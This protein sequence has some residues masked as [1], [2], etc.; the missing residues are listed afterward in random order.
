MD[1]TLQPMVWVL[2][3]T[4]SL[5]THYSPGKL[6]FNYDMIMQT[7][8]KVEWEFIKKKHKENMIK[9]NINKNL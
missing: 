4:A 8:V 5:T 3:T 6:S 7:K 9:N 2:H 1:Y